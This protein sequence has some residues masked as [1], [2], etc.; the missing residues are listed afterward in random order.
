MAKKSSRKGKKKKKAGGS[1]QPEEPVRGSISI[2]GININLNADNI[3]VFIILAVISLIVVFGPFQ[4]G[5]FFDKELLV[6]H[7]VTFALFTH[8]WV[9]RLWR[10]DGTLLKTPLDYAVA[11]LLLFYCLSFFVAANQRD[12]LGEI[13]KHCNYLAIYLMVVD[14]CRRSDLLASMFNKKKASEK[15]YGFK[16]AENTA[17]EGGPPAVTPADVIL[18]VLMFSG[19]AVAIGG[20]G[21]AVETWEIDGAYVRERLHTSLQYPNTAAA[22]LMASY[23]LALALSLRVTRWGYRLLYL[24]AATLI[25]TAFL[26]TESRGGLVLLFPLAFLLLLVSLSGDRLRLFLYGLV[27]FGISCV[28]F[29]FT[30]PLLRDAAAAPTWGWLA[31]AVLLSLAGGLI[32]EKIILLERRPKVVMGSA[33]AGLL[34]LALGSYAY[35]SLSGPVEIAKGQEGEE[36]RLEQAVDGVP[37]GENTLSLEFKALPEEEENSGESGEQ[38]GDAGWRIDIWT[39]DEDYSQERVFRESG[40]A[41]AEWEKKEFPLELQEEDSKLRVRFSADS[42]GTLV[43]ARDIVITGEDGEVIEDISFTLNRM[44]PQQVFDRVF[45]ATEMLHERFIHYEDA[46]SMIKDYPVLG[47]GGGG[48]DALYY[49]Y[50]QGDLHTTEVHSHFLQVWVETGT[51]GFLAFVGIWVAAVWAFVRGRFSKQRISPDKRRVITCAFVPALSLGV[52]SVVDFNLSLAA[53]TIFL[54]VLLG[55]IRG[56]DHGEGYPTSS[57]LDALN[58]RQTYWIPG[59]VGIVLGILLTVYS[60]F[61]WVGDMHHQRVDEVLRRREET[62]STLGNEHV[63]ALETATMLDPLRAD[64]YYI[65]AAYNLGQGDFKEAK[66]HYRKAHELEPYDFSYQRDYGDIM[67]RLGREKQ[68]KEILFDS[69]ELRPYDASSYQH[70]VKRMVD[71]LWQ[72]GR[73]ERTDVE[74]VEEIEKT[75][76]ERGVDP[77]DIAY[78]M[79]RA[80]YY[81]NN[82]IRARDYLRSV[83]EDHENYEEARGYLDRISSVGF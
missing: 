40:S 32:A 13:L 44:L 73:S 3:A 41:V 23:L 45:L 35:L 17:G 21:A 30:A 46:L 57:W 14:I 71:V 58:R 81:L 66:E 63:N 68:G 78:Q 38:A 24:P 6:V 4:R 11:A 15:T 52:H 37:A 69:I 59:V 49:T 25:S 31:L 51:L 43:K 12:A 54:F 64:N 72:E 27:T 55:V 33:V 42:P 65:L 70:V 67:F 76:E 82:Y 74:I 83:E 62:V 10:R 2:A 47:A 77:Y 16:Q 22:Y 56:L 9:T 53:V 18:H 29:L 20:M 50:H 61:L 5:L 79:G 36:A 26:L 1:L 28:V 75:M 7:I 60:I 34:V 8:W 39:I 80:Y 19:L 48:F